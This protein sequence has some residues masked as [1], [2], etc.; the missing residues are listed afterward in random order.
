MTQTL[1]I[2]RQ[3]DIILRYCYSARRAAQN[4]SAKQMR[5]TSRSF[6][7][8][9]LYKSTASEKI[10]SDINFIFENNLIAL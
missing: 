3:L 10:E 1:N 5:L 7:N 6:L 9:V 2:K 4:M 8:I